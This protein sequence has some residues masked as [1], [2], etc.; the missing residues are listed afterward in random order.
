[1]TAMLSFGHDTAIVV[2]RNGNEISVDLLSSARHQDEPPNSPGIRVLLNPEAPK[3]GHLHVGWA[4]EKM[5]TASARSAVEQVAAQ[6]ARTVFD[7]DSEEETPSATRLRVRTDIT[8]TWQSSAAQAARSLLPVLIQGEVG[9]EKLTAARSIHD[10]SSRARGPFHVVYCSVTHPPEYL[11]DL[12]SHFEKASNGTLCFAGIDELDM[13]TRS[14]LRLYLLE[15]FEPLDPTVRARI[16]ASSTRN[17]KELVAQ[18]RFCNQ[19]YA[20]LDYLSI[21][22]APLRERKNEIA[23]L[24]ITSVQKHAIDSQPELDPRAHEV[25]TNYRWPGNL[26]ELDQVTGRLAVMT[27]GKVI[28]KQDILDHAPW[29]VSDK[30][31]SPSSTDSEALSGCNQ[32]YKQ[33]SQ[34]GQSGASVPS[35]Q[36]IAARIVNKDLNFLEPMHEGVQRAIRWLAEHYQEP[37]DMT[38]LARVSHVSPSHLS[39]LLKLMLDMSFKTLLVRLRIEKAKIN[40]T[41]AAQVRVTD[42]ALE[43]GFNDVG[44]FAKVFRRLVGTTPREYRLAH[45]HI[46]RLRARGDDAKDPFPEGPDQRHLG[47][48]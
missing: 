9:T 17:L 13:R 24:F 47:A 27:S 36:E 16:I 23:P 43:V 6:C 46:P 12:P 37:V 29:L 22:I 20:T 35:S 8:N 39:A 31:D 19:L 28:S 44:H 1:M 7:A 48:S 40:L 42:V 2:S 18:G 4:S 26:Q 34:A 21:S 30:T 41:S 33:W 3:L 45:R 38:K 32:L 25:I 14:L 11:N 15:T 10:H 5:A